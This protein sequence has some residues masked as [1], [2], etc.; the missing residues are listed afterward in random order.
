MRV[1]WLSF[2]PFAG[3]VSL[4][5][6]MHEFHILEE[7]KKDVCKPSNHLK[8]VFFCKVVRER[9]RTYSFLSI[10][11]VIIRTETLD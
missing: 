1:Q 6:P 11:I 8:Q 2:L 7:Y 9:G 4:E 3:R 5:D 10:L